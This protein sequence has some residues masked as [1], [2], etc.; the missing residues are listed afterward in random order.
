[1]RKFLDLPVETRAL[2]LQYVPPAKYHW[3][4]LAFYRDEDYDTVKVWEHTFKYMT[5]AMLPLK[6]MTWARMYASVI[7]NDCFYKN[8]ELCNVLHCYTT[9]EVCTLC[10][11]EYCVACNGA[12]SICKTKLCKKC[13]STSRLARTICK[14]CMHML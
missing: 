9:L 12:C 13:S 1:M 4:I 3:I 6:P 7:S 5:M 11:H 2:I 14:N 10:R 8:C